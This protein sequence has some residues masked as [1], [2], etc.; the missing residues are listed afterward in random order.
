MTGVLAGIGTEILVQQLPTVLGLPGG[1]TTTVG[2]VRAVV[3]QLGKFNGWSLGIAAGVLA[4]VVV[5][6]R[7]DHRIPGALFGVA[8]ATVLVAAA[9]LARHG[10][11]VV[12]LID[13]ALPHLGLPDASLQQVGKLMATA[14]TV[15]FLCI[16]QTSATVRSNPSAAL[17]RGQA[18]GAALWTSTW[19]LSPSG[20]GAWWPAWP[21]PSR[22]NASPPRTAVVG[23]AGG[24]SQVAGLVAVGRRGRRP[25]RGHQPAEGPARGGLWGPY[26]FS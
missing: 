22:S 19:T 7:I 9:G 1:G 21:G 17:G 26:S 15:A 16:V 24:R 2:R 6:E 14:V 18:A 12:G 3:D 5:A 10:V 25:R 20:P 4:V 23:A 13:A 8:G 11:H